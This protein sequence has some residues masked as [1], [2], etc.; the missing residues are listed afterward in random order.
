MGRDEK[1]M[2]FGF[3]LLLISL[4]AFI[5]GIASGG[6]ILI[7][8]AVIVMFMGVLY[9][10]I[11]QARVG[12]NRNDVTLFPSHAGRARTRGVKNSRTEDF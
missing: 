4:V 10:R 8:P 9:V 11:R 1:Y 7:P 2:I 5:W 3:L 6:W 12:R